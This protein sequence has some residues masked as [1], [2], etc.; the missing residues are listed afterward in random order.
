MRALGGSYRSGLRAPGRYHSP[1]EPVPSLGRAL[2]LRL[3]SPLASRTG[4]RADTACPTS[5]DVYFV[6]HARIAPGAERP[7]L[8][9]SCDACGRATVGCRGVC[10][11]V[12]D[13][14]G[15]SRGTASPVESSAFADVVGRGWARRRASNR[16]AKPDGRAKPDRRKLKPGRRGSKP[17]G[18]GRFSRRRRPASGPTSRRRCGRFSRRRCRAS[19]PPWSPPLSAAVQSEHAPLEA[20]P[21]RP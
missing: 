2:T 9:T 18:A 10:G 13:G 5:R 8:W 17:D 6:G 12:D 3:P 15:G 11:T 1:L 14:C 21:P 4:Q 7:V 20:R 19:E 16:A